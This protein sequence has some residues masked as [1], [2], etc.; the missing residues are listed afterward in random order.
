MV[1]ADDTVTES[2]NQG[3]D[4]VKTAEASHTLA[5]NVENLTY[6][7]SSDFTG[8]GNTLANTLT[9]GAGDDTLDGGAGADTLIGGAGDDTYVVDTTSDVVTEASGEG[10]DTVNSSATYTL[11]SDVENLT[12]TGGDDIDG[13]GN[14]SANTLT[15]NTGANTLDG[16]AGVD[17]L[18]GGAGNDTYVVDNSSDVVTEA[19]GEGTDTVRASF[20]YTISD[21]D[22][23]LSLIHI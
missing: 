4:T 6:T 21:A 5:D 15:G 11:S 19:S 10:T 1:D 14:A 20:S 12:L 18:I 9:G 17:T 22:V 7:G 16:G 2:A 23:E 3:T 13:T 8:T